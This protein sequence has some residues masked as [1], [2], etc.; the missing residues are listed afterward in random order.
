M[1]LIFADEEETP[2]GHQKKVF[3]KP[4]C[5]LLVDDD[6]EVHAVTRLALK[7]F[8][9]QGSELELLSAY[10]AQAGREFFH[11]RDDIALAI[12]DVVMETDH[13]GLD[14]VHYVRNT[15]ENHRTRLVMRTGQ[16]GQAPEDRVIREYDI[17]DYKE[18]TDLTI[19]KLRTLLYSK[20]RAYRDLCIIEYQRDGL[21][22]VLDAT[23]MVQNAESLTVFATAVLDQLTSL[24]NLD[25]SALYCIVLPNGDNGEHESKTIAATGD[26]VQYSTDTRFTD[27]PEIVSQRFTQVLEKRAA[28]HFDDAYV[29][30]TAAKNGGCNLLYLKHARELGNM[31][32]QLLEIYTQSVAITF[33]NINLQ[34][35]LRETQKELV[36]TLADAVEA[37]SKD[38]G[39]HVKR[40][41]LTSEL[42]ARLYGLP[43]SQI[44][45]IKTASPLHDIGKAAIPDTILHKP[46]KLDADEWTLMQQHA[47]FGLDILQ[48]SNRPLMK[49]GAEIALSHHERWDGTGYPNGLAGTAIPV[50]G[51]ITALTD[52]FDA[53]GSRRSFKEPWSDEMVTDAIRQG[54]GTQFEPA[55][56]DLLLNNLDAFNAVR[57]EFPDPD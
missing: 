48:R 10:S 11:S 27:L 37:R 25:R 15:L 28:Q 12:V 39:A 23:S 3:K 16:P 42:L 32:R 21:A 56:V 35:E 57:R 49:L 52:V 9:F 44:V 53:L 13:A 17:D 6:A 31:D 40:V 7:G 55:L 36:Y 29:L 50:A 5:I 33:D 18:K 46:G 20:L 47:Q 54:R 1:E 2:S 41:A 38:S 8:E 4:W 34:E 30:Y 51:R 43:E 45:L 14:L 22:R 24:L 19:Q 26:F